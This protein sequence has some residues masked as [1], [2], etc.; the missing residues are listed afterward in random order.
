MMGAT[1][2]RTGI[3]ALA[4]LMTQSCGEPRQTSGTAGGEDAERSARVSDPISIAVPGTHNRMPSL[5]V[6]G[7]RVVVVWTS[8]AKDVMD[9]YASISED[10]GVTFSE[11]RRVNDRPGDVSSNAEQAPRVA[12]S[13]SAISVIWPSRL[14]G[15]S[16]IR[17]ARSTDGGRTFS[18]ARTLH[19]S[20]LTGARGW[21]GLTAG[22]DGV[23]H[24]VW[25]DGR[26]AAPSA[27]PH[28]HHGA[29][30]GAG[31]AH[32]GAPRQ[33]VYQAT[34]A[35]DGT[36]LESHVARDVCFCCKTAVGVGPEGRVIVAWRHIFPENMRDIALSTSVDGGRTFSQP[37]RVNED[38]WQL[39]GCPDDGPAMTIDPDGVSHLA[40]PT[41]VGGDT[42]QKAVVYAFTR[43]GRT[44]EPRLRL[45]HD[46]QEDA[47]HPQIASDAAGN[48][49]AVWDEQETDVRRIVLRTSLAGSGSF[50]APRTLN[51][52]GSAFYPAIAG[53]REG[54]IV[55][56]ASGTASQSAIALRRVAYE[57][58]R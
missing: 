38:K 43:D 42:P 28:R 13:A 22:R 47:A 29:T 23:V 32:E 37:V 39:S 9:V 34:I 14:D 50:D 44:F 6:L 56:W 21:Q 11:P 57:S 20:A 2:F 48:I 1:A 16:A 33:D 26:D 40:W 27:A 7:N 17:L 53:L 51:M 49:G 4:L 25:L 18:A 8:T 31:G 24:A 19:R 45:S 55:A 36:I 3:A 15:A 10:G 54:F 46:T 41:L 5:A 58:L 35:S 12:M 30:K 52:D